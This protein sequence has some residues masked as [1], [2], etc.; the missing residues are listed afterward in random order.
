MTTMHE[1]PGVL[2]ISIVIP[3]YNRGTA[4][5]ENVARCLALAPRPRE[6]ILVDDHSDAD[7]A[8]ALRALEGGPVKYIRLPTNSGQGLARS[9]G[10]ATAAGKYLVSLDDDS[11]FLQPDALQ[12]IWDRMASLP[13]CGILALRGFSPG[14]E[15]E[16]PRERLSL[17]S[18]HI[19]CG[20][21]YRAEVLHRAG[22]HLAFLRYEGEEADLSL[23]V[24]NTGADI[25]L[26][27]SITYF[28]NY[29]PTKRSRASL[30]NVRRLAVRNDLLRAWIY[31]PWHLAIAVSGWRALSHLR[32]GVRTGM[33]TSTVRGYVG[34]LLFLPRALAH[35]QPLSTATAQRYLTRRR[36]PEVLTGG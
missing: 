36:R 11:W 22:Y 27:E 28:H 21:A 6:I 18:D 2:D 35:R 16:P 3:S 30:L 23:K 14:L 29:D 8:R 31:F 34:F 20:A 33:L 19:T 15:I 26:D 13:N 9:V 32:W 24:M 7:S 10:F 17:V 5:S 1:T 25:V 4:V 12:R